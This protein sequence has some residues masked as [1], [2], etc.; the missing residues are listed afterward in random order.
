M[1][2]QLKETMFKKLKESMRM[3]SHQSENIN[4]DKNYFLKDQIEIIEFE[5]YTN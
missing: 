5:K 3:M 4:R 2:K 1:L